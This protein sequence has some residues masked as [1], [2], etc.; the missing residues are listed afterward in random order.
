MELKGTKI[1]V[2][3]LART[4]VAVTRF[5]AE[6]GAEVTVT[7]MRE[8]RD[9]AEALAELADLE[10]NY[11]LGR[12]VPQSF[13]MAD[14]IVVS[15]GVPMDIK[16]LEMA[17]AQGR[18]VVSEVELAS[19]FIDAPMV[20]IT[21][22]NGK[23]TTTTL[24]GTIFKACGFDT[25]VGGNI[26]NPLIELAASGERV[27]RVVVEL[28]SFQLE[29]VE[30]FRPNVAVLLNL[31]EDHLDRYANFQEYIDA[32]LRIFENQTA[33][34]FAVLNIDD[35][36]VAECA[37]R[38]K[39]RIFPMSRLKELD[40]G[41]FYRDGFITFAHSGKV[42]RFATAD[43]KLRGV[44][45]LDNI[46]ASLAATLLLRAEGDCAY[47]AVKSFKGLPH[48]M[49]FVATHNGVAWYED[50]KGTNVGSVVKSL[51]S[52]ESGI[53]LIAGGKDKGGSYAPLAPLV[54]ERVGHLI[55]IGE[56]KARMNEALGDL[57]ETH[58][59]ESLEEAVAIA[60]KV[61][62]PG[63]VVLFSPACSSFD[64]FKNYEER[65]ERFKTLV[66][67]LAAKGDA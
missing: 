41:I 14:L 25:F 56:A 67:G 47:Q 18:R 3:G 23:T 1:M 40:E 43:F 32:K 48:R 27:E 20:A 12:H 17:R 39:A 42:F 59:A 52:F 54:R 4:G 31:T 44:H 63:H 21:G 28:S 5:L 37:A 36:L 58:L 29:G 64:M 53:T 60:S 13:L 46:M 9:L 26:G 24:T 51:E 61:T 30:K 35:P 10:I 2:V 62:T 16:P 8:E 45:N 66:H 49:E 6:R 55:L 11:E 15:P 50:S 7:D 38:I 33:E 65:A 19:W 34:D 57:T 22:T